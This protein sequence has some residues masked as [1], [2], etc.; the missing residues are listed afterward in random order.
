MISLILSILSSTLILFVFKIIEKRRIPLFPP[1]VVNYLMA[2]VL[3]FALNGSNPLPLVSSLPPWIIFSV[4]IGVL[5]I[6][7]FYL[8]GSS[9]QKAGIAVT[10]IAAKM[11]F[12]IP[13]LF[14]LLYDV[15]D[16]FSLTKLVLI[17][18]AVIA[19]FLVVKPNN[20]KSERTH[21]VI[22]PVAIFV[23]LGL[24]DSLIKY[25]QYH[26]IGTAADS[27]L[28]SGVNFTVAGLLGIG[29]LLYSRNQRRLLLSWKVWISGAVLGAANFGSMYF[30]IN[31][32]NDLKFNNSL[33]FG[34]NNIG[35]V[36]LSVI[37]AFVLFRERFSLI[38]WVGLLLSLLVLLGMIKVFI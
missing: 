30:L 37:M 18:T 34:I 16:S 9:T 22:L 7:N 35:I 1:I 6:V 36:V 8:I 4:V 26:Y 23:G 3:G 32:L 5:L 14:S 25:S 21:H 28:F 33:V 19:V 15:N 29:A 27:S 2:S 31:A 24:L 20:L 11:S 13:V 12:V 38:N 17:S 10:S